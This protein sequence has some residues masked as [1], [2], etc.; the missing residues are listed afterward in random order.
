[1]NHQK[2]FFESV[3]VSFY[4][5]RTSMDKPLKVSEPN[6]P[7]ILENYL[8]EPILPEPKSKPKIKKSRKNKMKYFPGNLRR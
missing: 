8:E 1:M 3:N 2:I 6:N 5:R 7:E 4:R